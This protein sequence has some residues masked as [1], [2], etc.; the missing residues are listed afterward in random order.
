[1]RDRVLEHATKVGIREAEVWS[2]LEF[3][4]RLRRD[5]PLLVR[6]FFDGEPFPEGRVP[7]LRRR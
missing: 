6:R 2:G 5:Q 1:M 7:R 4:E 3:E